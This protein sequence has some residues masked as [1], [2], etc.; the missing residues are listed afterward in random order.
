MPTKD[1]YDTAVMQMAITAAKDMYDRGEKRID[2]F[3]DKYGDFY[4]PI[5]SDVDYVYNEGEGKLKKAIADL[6]ARGIDPV[7]S[8]EG[9]AAVQ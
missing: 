3:Y 8:A 7:R 6:Y 4:S 2:E 5:A 9:R 1:L